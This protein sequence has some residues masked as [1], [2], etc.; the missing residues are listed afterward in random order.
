MYGDRYYGANASTFIGWAVTAVSGVSLAS[1]L[2]TDVPVLEVGGSTTWSAVSAVVGVGVGVALI[3]SKETIGGIM[4]IAL[5]ASLLANGV[6]LNFDQFGRVT[7][8]A[9]NG[10]VQGATAVQGGVRGATGA[11]NTANNP[12]FYGYT[13]GRKLTAE[14]LAACQSGAAWTN[15]SA[16]IRNCSSGHVWS[17]AQ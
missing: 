14:E 7:K 10:F 3:K 4:A 9:Y 6:S 15:T 8:G 16:G 11:T 13:E 1:S 12:L 17:K 2:L 5:T